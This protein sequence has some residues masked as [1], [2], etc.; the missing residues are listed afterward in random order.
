[1]LQVNE[2]FGHCKAVASPLLSTKS[3]KIIT[4]SAICR[5][6]GLEVQHH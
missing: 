3:R 6:M 5:R 4:S 2:E 1:M